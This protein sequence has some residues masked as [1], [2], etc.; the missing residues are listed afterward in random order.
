MLRNL[1]G[2][3]AKMAG[4]RSVHL[5]RKPEETCVRDQV[6][7]VLGLF[8]TTESHLGTWDVFLRVF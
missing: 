1:F 6:I 5:L 2:G 7:P 4:G 8:K 3:V